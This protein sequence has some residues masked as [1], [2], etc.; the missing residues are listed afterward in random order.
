MRWIGPKSVMIWL[1][2][3]GDLDTQIPGTDPLLIFSCASAKMTMRRRHKIISHLILAVLLLAA[4][5]GAVRAATSSI[6]ATGAET[7]VSR[8]CPL[9]GAAK[10]T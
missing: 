9:A 3:D 8:G 2:P 4:S 5:S 7:E 6:W 1:Q 10:D